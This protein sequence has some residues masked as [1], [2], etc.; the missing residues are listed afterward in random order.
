MADHPYRYRLARIVRCKRNR[1]GCSRDG[2]G[3]EVPACGPYRDLDGFA[4]HNPPVAITIRA[5]PSHKHPALVPVTLRP[6]PRIF[7]YCGGLPTDPSCRL[8]AHVCNIYVGAAAS[9][10]MGSEPLTAASRRLPRQVA[11]GRFC[12]IKPEASKTTCKCHSPVNALIEC[13]YR[14]LGTGTHAALATSSKLAPAAAWF[15][16]D[17]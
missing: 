12:T 8:E 6:A 15:C 7:H 14:A 9:S 5:F 17:F 16:A 11:A 4:S 10:P 13:A 2:A 3:G 1:A